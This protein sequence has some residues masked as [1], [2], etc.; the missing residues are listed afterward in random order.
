MA[1]ALNLTVTISHQHGNRSQ[2][3]K[4]GRR[5][6]SQSVNRGIDTVQA[7]GFAAEEPIV[8]GDISGLPELVCFENQD[9]TNYIEI[10]R[11]IAATFEPF[12]VIRPGRISGPVQPAAGVTW[13]AKA[14]TAACDL[15]VC[16]YA[17]VLS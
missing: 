6:Y 5:T 7:I 14:N 10:G 11:V 15:R 16:A 2:P 17:G 4:P 8:W 9:A 13:Y 3:F 12:M 1:G